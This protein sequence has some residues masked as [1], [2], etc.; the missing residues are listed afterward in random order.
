MQTIKTFHLLCFPEINLEMLQHR[1]VQCDL[2]RDA[3]LR[4]STRVEK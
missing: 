1:R 3:I 4:V 2:R